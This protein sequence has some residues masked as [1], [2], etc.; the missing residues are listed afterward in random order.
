MMVSSLCRQ[1]RGS[2][3]TLAA[4]IYHDTHT[5]THTYIHTRG[6]VHAMMVSSVC[7]DKI[8]VA[9]L[10]A[11]KCAAHV[12]TQVCM[13]VCMYV[14]IDVCMHVCICTITC[15]YAARECVLCMYTH[16]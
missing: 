11:P 6:G 7:E 12:F 8:A 3:S 2:P 16:V 1:G 5:Y 14:C 15:M 13:Y 10:L 9:P 4:Y